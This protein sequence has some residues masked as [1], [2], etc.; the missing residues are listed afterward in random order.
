MLMIDGLIIVHLF[1][2]RFENKVVLFL[3][4]ALRK[5]AGHIVWKALDD[6]L[7]GTG[8]QREREEGKD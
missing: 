8:W 4:F 2:S 3:L 7:W 1:I 6:K 5:E